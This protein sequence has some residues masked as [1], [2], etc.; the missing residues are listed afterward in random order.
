ME[1]LFSKKGMIIWE[2]GILGIW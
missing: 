1:V 2:L